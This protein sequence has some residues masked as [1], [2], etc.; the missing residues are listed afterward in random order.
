M[1]K[2]AAAGEPD[3]TGGATLGNSGEPTSIL[4]KRRSEARERE[5]KVRFD[6]SQVP[7]VEVIE[8]GKVAGQNVQHFLGLYI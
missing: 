8:R 7:S 2:F 1:S 4:R 3:M 5:K 6:E